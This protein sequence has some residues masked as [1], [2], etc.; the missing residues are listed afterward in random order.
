MRRTFSCPRG[1]TIDLKRKKKYEGTLCYHNALNFNDVLINIRHLSNWTEKMT[2]RY[3]MGIS[4][5]FICT[6][7]LDFSN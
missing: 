7:L 6:E 3:C 2:T 4:F 1:E 5:T